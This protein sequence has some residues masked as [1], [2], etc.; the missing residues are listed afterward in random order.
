MGQEKSHETHCGRQPNQEAR[1]IY[2][3][4]EAL[5]VSKNTIHHDLKG[6]CST[7]EQLNRMRWCWS[8]G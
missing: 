8:R 3:A 7:I 1:M 5:S 2:L 6:N 4:R